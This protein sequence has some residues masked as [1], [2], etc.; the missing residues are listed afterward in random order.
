RRGPGAGGRG[1]ACTE[2]AHQ[3]RGINSPGIN[4]PGM[5]SLKI[6]PHMGAYNYAV[7]RGGV[8][9]LGLQQ[10]G[11]PWMKKHIT[12]ILFITTL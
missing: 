2:E 3:R 6:L 11:E 12:T 9:P 4:S 7:A 5:N 8:S 10:Q 1:T